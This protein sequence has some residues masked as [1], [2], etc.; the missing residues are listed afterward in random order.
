MAGLVACLPAWLADRIMT[1]VTLVGFAGAVV[2]L[3]WRVAG[4]RGLCT[5]AILASILA[6]NIAWLFGFTSFMLGACLFPITLGVWW[7]GRDRLSVP[8]LAV[9]TTLL[10]LGYFCHL[11][12]LGLTALGLLVL[13]MAAPVRT[14]GVNPWRQRLTRLARIGLTFVPVLV[15]G[16]CYLRIATGRAPM[17]PRWENLADPC[18]PRAWMA[19]LKWVDPISLA[20][21]DGLPFTDR[22]GWQFVLF[23]PVIWLAIAI[24]L[25]CY[26]QCRSGFLIRK[27]RDRRVWF[28]LTA[29]LVIGG[30]AGPD[31][32]GAAHGDYLPQRIVLLGLVAMVPILD[33]DF[34]RTWGRGA[35]VAL[36]LAAVPSID[37]HL[38]LCAL[39]GPNRR[40]GH[41]RERGDK[42]PPEDRGDFG[43]VAQPISSQSAL[44]RRQLAGSRHRQCDLEQL[45]DAALLLSRAVPTG[46]RSTF[47]GRSGVD[48][49]YR[50]SKRCRRAQSCVGMDAAAACEFHRR[51][52]RLENRPDPGLDH[53]ALV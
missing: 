3:R 51:C 19:R 29:I 18:S 33:I 43:F 26:G 35:T 11:V 28:L 16:L 31:S 15:L 45:R 38:G 30:V 44:T 25:W 42:R 27:D 4:S 23:A 13:S 40:P 22:D 32:L 2:W 14:S 39:L 46:N 41:S 5:T 1:S 53:R 17:N 47:S 48:L 20:I 21:R 50:R 9:L 34:A 7:E 12:S 52:G 6:M 10:T 37:H 49:D 24:I 8:R 36:V